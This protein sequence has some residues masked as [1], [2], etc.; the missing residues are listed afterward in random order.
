MDG[1]HL[2]TN[3]YIEIFVKGQKYTLLFKN[4][5][6][7]HKLFYLFFKFNLNYQLWTSELI[8]VLNASRVLSSN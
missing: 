7:L 2:N 4:T 6:Q 5:L 8:Y 1:Q 3:A